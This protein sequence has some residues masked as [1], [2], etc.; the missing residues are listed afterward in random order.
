[1]ELELGMK[2]PWSVSWLPA[3]LEDQEPGLTFGMVAQRLSGSTKTTR[4]RCE[5]SR[6]LRG[7]LYHHVTQT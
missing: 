6:W 5:G 1:M 7:Y 2:K 4:Q 3:Y